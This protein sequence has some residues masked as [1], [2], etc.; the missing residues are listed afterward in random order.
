MKKLLDSSLA[1]ALASGFL[2]C[3]GRSYQESFLGVY[4]LGASQFETSVA[5][6]LM[7]GFTV[8]YFWLRKPLLVTL[9]ALAIFGAARYAQKRWTP[10]QKAVS[11]MMSP[12]RRYRRT[13][14]VLGA[15]VVFTSAMFEAE[16]A[17]AGSALA[18]LRRDQHPLPTD[19]KDDDYVTRETLRLKKNPNE[20]IVGW[21]IAQNSGEYAF[22]E[23]QSRTVWLVRTSRCRIGRK[24]PSAT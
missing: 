3:L 15:L 12:L 24:S 9:V 16:K 20:E 6:T 13:F 7:T 4:G 14:I 8:F 23:S 19:R 1:L 17:G 2:F 18:G 11:I 5:R 22:Y 21:L 10:F